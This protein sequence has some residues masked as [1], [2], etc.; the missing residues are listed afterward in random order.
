MPKMC[1]F[2]HFPNWAKMG[3]SIDHYGE[4]IKDGVFKFSEITSYK[5]Y[6]DKK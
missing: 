1:I 6:F 3:Y 4:T 2:W 5:L